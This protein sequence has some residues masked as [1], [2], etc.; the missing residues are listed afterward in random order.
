ML[1]GSHGITLSSC[2]LIVLDKTSQTKVCNLAHQV[3]SDQDV[4]GT[5]I[6]V[7]VVHSFNV[8]H[9]SC[10]LQKERQGVH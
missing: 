9:S 8:R 1:K 10:N 3:V 4:G 7:N 2:V 6:T 5:Q